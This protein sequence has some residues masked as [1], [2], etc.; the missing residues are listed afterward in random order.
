MEKYV[1]SEEAITMEVQ[2]D[3]EPFYRNCFNKFPESKGVDFISDG[4]NV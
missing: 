3:D 1:F 4:N 2:F